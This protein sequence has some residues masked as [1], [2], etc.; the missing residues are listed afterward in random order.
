MYYSTKFSSHITVRIMPF[1]AWHG[2]VGR[3]QPEPEVEASKG[4]A[5]WPPVKLPGSLKSWLRLLRRRHRM[6]R[7]RP[8]L[9][10]HCRPWPCGRPPKSI[11]AVGHTATNTSPPLGNADG[12]G[13][14]SLPLGGWG[15][16]LEICGRAWSGAPSPGRQTHLSG[17]GN[18]ASAA[19]KS[20][21]G[22]DVC[23]CW[24]VF[25]WRLK[26]CSRICKTQK[27][28]RKT[29]K[30]WI[31]GR[32]CRASCTQV[33]SFFPPQGPTYRGEKPLFCFFLCTSARMRV[34]Y[35]GIHF[36]VPLCWFLIG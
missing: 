24:C 33:L 8:S 2:M 35:C 14:F 18:H 6:P 10:L 30:T 16:G 9:R 27:P 25:S 20:V 29:W 7:G 31:C 26:S 12:Q 11:I 15:A 22:P 4:P 13:W 5:R 21:L 23:C 28:V 32:V 3:G 34:W 36:K 1:P 17:I 19:L